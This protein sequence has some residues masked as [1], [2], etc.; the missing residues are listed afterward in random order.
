L[1]GIDWAF[2]NSS[3]IDLKRRT[4]TFESDTLR[5]ITPLDLREGARYTEPVREDADSEA[6]G[7]LY[8]S[9]AIRED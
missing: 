2:Y 6:I 4:I 1:L 5:L 7:E 8:N 3:L 9:T